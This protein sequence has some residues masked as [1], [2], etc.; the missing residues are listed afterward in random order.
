[1]AHDFWVTLKDD[2]AREWQ[3]VAGVS[4]LPVH[5]PIPQLANLPGFAVPCRV[6]LVAIDQLEDGVLD[7]IARRLAQKFGLS[8]EE[9]REEIRKAGIPIREEHIS[10]V[11]VHSPQRWF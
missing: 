8:A 4:R 2:V 7:C 10:A 1:M 6:F 5:T 3:E 9:A 11:A